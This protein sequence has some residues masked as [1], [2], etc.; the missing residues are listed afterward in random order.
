MN[1]AL[2]ILGVSTCAANTA[3]AARIDL[4]AQ[5][6][7]VRISCVA[8][9]SVL[10]AYVKLGTNTVVA[11]AGTASTAASGSLT[12]T[13]QAATAQTV[14]I[15]DRVYTWRTTLS[16][17][18]TIANEVLRGANAAASVANLVVAINAGATEG[19]NYSTGTKVHGSVTAIDDTGD[20]VTVTA[21]TPGTGGNAIATSDTSDN[22]AW[23][24]TF[25]A[26]GADGVETSVWVAA[27]ESIVVKK[28]GATHISAIGIGANTTVVVT[29][30]G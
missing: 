10:G 28:G 11:A 29:A 15:G 1:N 6:D 12:L 13:G 27:G 7:T 2:S 17:G 24:A 3:S 14:T 25:L 8:A 30:L 19:T 9:A 23:G 5:G 16:T 26:S 18:P 22:M 21:K 20:V 4:P